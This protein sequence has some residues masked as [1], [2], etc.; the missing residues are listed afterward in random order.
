MFL[1]KLYLKVSVIN[2][3]IFRDPIRGKPEEQKNNKWCKPTH[4]TFSIAA[5]QLQE[6]H[7][8]VFKHVSFARQKHS[9]VPIG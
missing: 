1:P 5:Q 3:K 7:S 8:N 9:Q 4:K 2:M 6:S